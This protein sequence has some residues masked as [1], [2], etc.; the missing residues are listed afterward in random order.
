MQRFYQAL[1]GIDKYMDWLMHHVTKKWSQ[2][3]G[4]SNFVLARWSLRLAIMLITVSYMYDF[5]VERDGWTAF[6]LLVIGP[7]WI[8]WGLDRLKF[9]AEIEREAGSMSDALNLNM[10]RLQKFVMDRLF[11]SIYMILLTPGVMMGRLASTGF[12]LF[13][14]SHYFVMHFDCKGGKSL[15]KRAVEALQ[16]VGSK[17]AEKARDL[18]PSPQPIPV[19]IGA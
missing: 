14:A 7:I 11:F 6:F 5:Y 13:G 17:V 16:K 10:F 12:F 18:I 3:T 8:W 19:P 2:I 4:R 1:I 15:A 9:F